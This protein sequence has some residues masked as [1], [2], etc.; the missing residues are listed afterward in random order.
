[1]CFPCDLS[2]TY[3]DVLKRAAQRTTERH[4]LNRN[5]VVFTEEATVM[6]SLLI[7]CEQLTQDKLAVQFIMKFFIEIIEA[8]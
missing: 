7:V 2:N 1:M 8:L 5:W 6:S 3:T 4:F